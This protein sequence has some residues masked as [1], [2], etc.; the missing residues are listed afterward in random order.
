MGFSSETRKEFA[1]EVSPI[2]FVDELK[3]AQ[4]SLLFEKRIFEVSEFSTMQ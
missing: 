3:K 1:A 2:R 4:N